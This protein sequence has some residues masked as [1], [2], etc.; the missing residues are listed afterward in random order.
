MVWDFIPNGLLLNKSTPVGKVLDRGRWSQIEARAVELL[1]SI[2]PSPSSELQRKDVV[3]YLQNLLMNSIPCQVFTFGSVPL[4]T[5]LPDGDIDL[6]TFVDK[7][8]LK[9]SMIPEVLDILKHEEKREVAQFHV[10]EVR[11]IQTEIRLS[12]K[13]SPLR[14]GTLDT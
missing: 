2:Q 7:Q 3:A 12:L 8:F 9:D 1:S 5:Y 10:K 13:P 14:E 6:P 4:K 11:Y